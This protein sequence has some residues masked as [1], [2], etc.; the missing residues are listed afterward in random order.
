LRQSRGI[1]F[2]LNHEIK[3]ES[4]SNY[5]IWADVC[6]GQRAFIGGGRLLVA[7][8]DGGRLLVSYARATILRSYQV[9]IRAIKDRRV[10]LNPILC[11]FKTLSIIYWQLGVIRNNAVL[12]RRLSR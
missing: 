8:T 4:E 1:L 7:G 10:L 11:L 3:S 2:S 5:E 12:Q 9:A 6:Q